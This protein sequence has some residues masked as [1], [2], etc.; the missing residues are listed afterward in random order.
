MK[1]LKAE[2][3]QLIIN[4]EEPGWTI[5]EADLGSAELLNYQVNNSRMKQRSFRVNNSTKQM[6]SARLDSQ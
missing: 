5:R 6:R 1:V 3:V 2:N 4:D